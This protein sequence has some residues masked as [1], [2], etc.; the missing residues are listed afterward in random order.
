M[1]YKT[2]LR[3]TSGEW[4]LV[5]LT[6]IW[7]ATFLVIRTG[8]AASGPF[9]FIG[10]R[11]GVAALVMTLLSLS[12]LRGVTLREIVAGILIGFF[13][14]LGAALQ[15]VGL[16][17]IT[18]SKSAFITSFYVPA[19]PIMQ[20]LIFR[21]PPQLKA[22]LGIAFAFTGLLLLAGP[23][24]VSAGFGKGELFTF[25]SA[26]AIAFEIVLISFF[27]PSVSVLR[28][29]I[30]QVA[31][32]SVLAF[33]CMPAYGE[34]IPPFSWALALSAGGLGLA[35][36]IIQSVMVWA[37][38]KIS[39]TRATV[40]YAGEPIWGGLF[41]RMFGER[42]PLL[43]FVGCAFIVAGVLISDLKVKKNPDPNA[44]PKRQAQTPKK[45]E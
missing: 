20:W 30:I 9:F 31:V 10:V 33:S 32:T 23:D 17:S 44:K 3:L 35:S 28:V 24:G 14:F 1:E 39:A 42:L 45:G 19:V 11:F 37:Q 13:L 5:G 38:R 29:S 4:A 8:L 40:I 26:V 43:A 18:A 22:W 2:T 12:I 15:T 41:G 6:I 16:L 25:I 7:G 21:R 36:A 27:A 34:S